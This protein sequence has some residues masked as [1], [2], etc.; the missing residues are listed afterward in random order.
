MT[1]RIKPKLDGASFAPGH[2][3]VFLQPFHKTQT[4]LQPLSGRISM[5]TS[6]STA[7]R[8]LISV[9]HSKAELS[10]ACKKNTK[11]QQYNRIN[12]KLYDVL[13]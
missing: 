8:L 13:F 12:R 4:P 9:G 7:E 1:G 5:A 3:R 6:C 2:P 10:G 11:T